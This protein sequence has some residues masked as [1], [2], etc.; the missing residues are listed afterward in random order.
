MSRRPESDSENENENENEK[1]ER[2][3]I[4]GRPQVERLVP[5]TAGKPKTL[6][7]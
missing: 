6:S 4:P 1:E 5:A 7:G 3:I 2:R